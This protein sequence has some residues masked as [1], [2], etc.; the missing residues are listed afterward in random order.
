MKAIVQ[1]ALKL[2]RPIQSNCSITCK[3]VRNTKPINNIIGTSG[4]NSLIQ[5]KLYE[6]FHFNQTPVSINNFVKVEI[7]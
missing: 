4:R 5:S 7:S 2:Y 3:E 6:V 1:V